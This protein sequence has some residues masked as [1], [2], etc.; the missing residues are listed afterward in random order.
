VQKT[1][2]LKGTVPIT[3]VLKRRLIDRGVKD[4]FVKREPADPEFKAV[5]DYRRMLSSPALRERAEAL[6]GA[7]RA[8]PA[9]LPES[10]VPPAARERRKHKRYATSFRAEFRVNIGEP[11]EWENADSGGIVI[12]M[13]AGGLRMVTKRPLSVGQQFKF[14]LQ[15][16]RADGELAGVAEVVRAERKGEHFEVGARFVYFGAQKSETNA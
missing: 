11:P 9:G 5:G 15:S 2:I 14:T 1:L 13:S 8:I 12:D 7:N 10:P 4:V 3:A 6:K 16:G